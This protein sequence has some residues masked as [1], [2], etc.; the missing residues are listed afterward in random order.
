MAESGLFVTH[1]DFPTPGSS[2]TGQLPMGSG[3]ESLGGTAAQGRVTNRS[4][5][6]TLKN[7]YANVTTNSNTNTVTLAVRI[8]GSVANLS[9][10]VTSGTTGVL[11]DLSGSDAVAD[12]DTFNHTAAFGASGVAFACLLGVQYETSGQFIF[13]PGAGIGGP[14]TQST[15]STSYFSSSA[16]RI[17]LS[18]SENVSRHSAIG[19]TTISK[20]QFQVSANARSTSTVIISRNNGADGNQTATVTASS[21]G[22]FEDTSNSDSVSD[23]NYYS[24]KYTLGTGSGSFTIRFNS[25]RVQTA[26]ESQCIIY[27]GTGFALAAAASANR[28]F[29][30]NLK[31][32]G[33]P[34]P[35]GARASN[36]YADI[37]ANTV[38]A[39]SS[40]TL[41]IAG[42]NTALTA[43][44][45]A[46]TTGRFI[47]TTHTVQMAAADLIDVNVTAG[48]TG[49]TL[50]VREYGMLVNA[51]ATRDM[52]GTLAAD[53][54]TIAGTAKVNH[55]MT[56]V[57]AAGASTI[58]G[59]MYQG[60]HMTGVL[61]AGS[62]SIAGTATLVHT[63]V[64]VLQAGSATITGDLDIPASLVTMEGVLVA[65]SAT[66]AGIMTVGGPLAALDEFYLLGGIYNLRIAHPDPGLIVQL[67]TTVLGSGTWIDV[68]IPVIGDYDTHLE[69]PPG[70]YRFVSNVVG[71]VT[72]SLVPIFRR[73][74]L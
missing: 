23:G 33:A 34:V 65:G 68:S 42:S 43:S 28:S 41:R 15:A 13:Q 27:G 24:T 56:G 30:N 18:T 47:D 58:A 66:M 10:S 44:I 45:T 1:I 64:G 73:G 62:S 6:G 4:S 19:A 53:A 54:S 9:I 48:G 74:P 14:V 3:Q 40:I 46:N 52:T 36:L 39:A 59:Q 49:T 16:G 22:L 11:S 61:Q 60:L 57:L 21:T 26:G 37:S 51:Y 72:K 7:F 35:M 29:A 8:N 25:Y 69:L 2:V 5:A 32:G 20:L 55:T 63:L 70:N 17:S 12:G 38:S 71:S 31:T 67:Q 50:T